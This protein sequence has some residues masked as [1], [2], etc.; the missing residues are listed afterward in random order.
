MQ[1]G[2][3]EIWLNNLPSTLNA[4]MQETRPAVNWVLGT[5]K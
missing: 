1:R 5:A 2:D 4:E 3:G